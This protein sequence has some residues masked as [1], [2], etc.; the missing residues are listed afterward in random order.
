MV[1]FLLPLTFFSKT[2]S[3]SIAEPVASISFWIFIII[4][5]IQLFRHP[6]WYKRIIPSWKSIILGMLFWIIQ[7][8]AMFLSYRIT[9]DTKQTS[10]IIHSG[11]ILFGW[12]AAFYVAWAVIQVTVVNKDAEKKFFK[13]G[14]IGLL[15]YL[16]LV[17]IPQILV[18]S[19]M[20]GLSGYV[21]LIASAFEKRWQS[22]GNYNFNANGAYVLSQKRVNGFE[23]EASY[24]AN[25]LSITYLP[26]LIGLTVSGEKI[27]NKIKSPRLQQLANVCITF[28]LF[29]VLIFAKT[30][31]GI[32]TG[33]L[34]FILWILFSRKA[35]KKFLIVCLIAG[36]IV[37]Y[38]LYSFV[39]MVHE[40][41]NQFLFAKQ[42][43]DNRLGGAIGLF[44]TF[45][46]HPIIGVGYGFTSFFNIQ[47]VPIGLT[48]NY[49]FQEIFKN[50][51]FPILSEFLGWLASYGLIIMI[52]ALY[53]MFGFFMKA[54]LI[55]KKSHSVWGMDKWNDLMRV[56]FVVT[57]ILFFW[58]SFIVR[59]Y[60]WPCL[61]MFF[62]YRKHIM[63]LEEELKQ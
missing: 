52:P 16:S 34:G 26:M 13:A 30:T 7:L 23:P 48:H 32:I 42:G 53:M 15:L 36:P 10:G 56:S 51:G 11:I 33:A 49:E 62:F 46:T 28:F 20:H 5:I 54:L 47:N 45:L 24:L 43:T 12:T 2:Y 38:F 21:N 61:L 19:K 27:W 40:T 29:F 14:I 6:M 58:S 39:P 1:N 59:L 50:H 37:L 60:I 3:N 18:L 41:L 9:G 17:I 63:R 31:T 8:V 25:L 57:F 55:F 22:F 4:I 44:L 35:L